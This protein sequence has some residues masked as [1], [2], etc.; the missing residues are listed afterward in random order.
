MSVMVD[1]TVNGDEQRFDGATVGEVVDGFGKG[2]RGVAVALN[3]EVVPRSRWDETVL[4]HG[5]RMEILLA[6][7]GG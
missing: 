1:V 3:E 6:A 7:Q 4:R 5:D 2:R